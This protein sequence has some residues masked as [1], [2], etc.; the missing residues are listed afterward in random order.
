MTDRMQTPTMRRRLARIQRRLRRDLRAHDV[1][2]RVQLQ[3]YRRLKRI[4][5][6]R[7]F[8]K[9]RWTATLERYDS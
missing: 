2:G 8:L 7:V 3:L 6:P 4:N 5:L 1:P 9:Y